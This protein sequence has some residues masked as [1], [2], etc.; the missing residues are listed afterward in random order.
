MTILEGRDYYK[1]FQYPWAFEKYNQQQEMHWLP[2][3][4]KNMSKD[5]ADLKKLTPEEYLLVTNIQKFFTQSDV[6]VGEGYVLKYGPVFG[7]HPELRMMLSAFA[8]MEAIHAH[9][10]SLWLDT[11]GLPESEYQA[12][13]EYEVLRNKHTFVESFNMADPLAMAVTLAVY[14]GFTEGMQLFSAFAMLLHFAWNRG[15][16]TGMGQIVTYSIRDE[17]LHVEGMTQLFRT[18]IEEEGLDTPELWDQ[19]VSACMTMVQH[20]KKFIDLAFGI[21]KEI[22]ASEGKPPLTKA[23]MYAYVDFIA[24]HRL[25]QLGYRGTLPY[26]VLKNP[27]PWID[28]ALKSVEFANFFETTV[29]E[30]QLG[31]LADFSCVWGTYDD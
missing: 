19:V 15:Q 16:L 1:P 27:L 11:V 10:Y 9:A 2:A 25:R 30:Y 23:D 7:R 20:E 8:N 21:C 29:T 3:D 6:D 17:D 24:N 18:F 13:K 14:S 4:I 12:F 26:G 28:D 31:G 5:V 22:P